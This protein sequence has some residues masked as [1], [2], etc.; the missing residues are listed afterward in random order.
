MSSVS[1]FN[2]LYPI[3]LHVHTVASTHAYS[4]VNEYVLMAKQ[5][6]LKLINITD[7]GP[8][9]SDAP[10]PWHFVNMKVL[11]RVINDVIVLRSIEGNIT[12]EGSSD[13][14]DYL[15]GFLDIIMAGFHESVC[16]P[17]T[18]EENTAI[19]LKLMA[20]RKVQII[21]HPGNPKYPIDI[22]TVAKAAAENNVALELN[23]SSFLHSRKGSAENCMAIAKAVKEA[24]GFLALGSDSHSAYSVG[25]FDACQRVISEIQFPQERILNHSLTCLF[26]FIQTS[27]SID[28]RTDPDL[29][30]YV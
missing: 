2:A 25:T 30:G 20:S 8:D 26:E 11:P 10:H 4:T 19:L 1:S 13:V 23:N 17:G 5:R 7:H 22:A 27:R 28:L 21:T 16:Q 29:K 3:D 15:A 9:G 24:G 18:R 6:G 12:A 14:N